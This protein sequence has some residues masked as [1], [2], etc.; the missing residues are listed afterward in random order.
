[1]VFVF[2]DCKVCHSKLNFAHGPSFCCLFCTYISIRSELASLEPSYRITLRS[3]G[4][5]W[6]GILKDF[7]II[8]HISF[9]YLH[10]HF[11]HF[12]PCGQSNLIAVLQLVAEN[13]SHQLS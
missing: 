2:K 13:S 7:Y 9:A 8:A 3:C 4:V 5:S 11:R 6:T 1:M 10:A 12:V